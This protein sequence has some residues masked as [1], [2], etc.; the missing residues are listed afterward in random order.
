MS[1]VE[2]S[3]MKD[4]ARTE[5]IRSEGGS[6]HK[7][8]PMSDSDSSDSSQSS[9]S[10]SQ[11]GSE[12]ESNSSS[13]SEQENE[14]E[15]NIGSDKE[16]VMSE[17]YSMDSRLDIHSESS[18][19]LTTPTKLEDMDSNSQNPD[20]SRGNRQSRLKDLKVMWEENPD[21]YGVRRSGRSRKEPERYNIGEDSEEND[22]KGHQKPSRRQRDSGEWQASDSSD[23]DESEQ[24]CAKSRQKPSA[25]VST[26]GRSNR[27]SGRSQKKRPAPSRRQRKH[28]S[29]SE[30]EDEYDTDEDKTRSTRRSIKKVRYAS[31]IKF[32]IE[33]RSNFTATGADTTVYA[34]E[35]KGDPND[36]DAP[37]KEMQFLIKWK[38]WSHLHNTWESDASLRAQ[39][40]KGMKKVENY[41]KREEEIRLWKDA[42]TREDIEYYDCQ[43]EMTTELQ[44]RQ[45]LVERIIAENK[46]EHGREPDYLIKWE[47]LPYSEAT[48]EDG[49]L[50]TRK[51]KKFIDD[52]C[53]RQK[54][55]KIPTK[56]CKVLKVRPKFVP[57]KTQP[58][59][60][61]GRDGLE[62]RDYQLEGV[63]WLAHSW[64]RENGVILA[65]EMGLGKTIQT[66]GFLSYLMN[67]HSLYGPFL[68]VVPLSTMNSWQREFSLWAPE[69]NVVVYIGDISSRNSIRQYEWCHPG[70][71]RL[72]FNVLLTTYEILLK[73]KSFLGGVSWAVL[74]VDEA[75]RLK[76]D[77]SLLYKSLF[78]FDTNHRVL[79][80]GTPLQNSLK[81]LWALLHFIM[82]EKF[83]SWEDFEQEHKDSADKGYS[84][85]HKQLEPFILRRVKKDVEKSLPAKVEQ[86]LRVEMSSIQKQYYRWILTKNYR[87]LSKGLKGSVAG[88][89]NI[90]MELKKCCNH[91][92]LIRPP[93]NMGNADIL[94]TIVRGSG[95]L[96]LL[97]K[98]L[99]RLKETGHRVLI[100]S[101]MVQMLDIISD[102]LQLK[103]FTFQRLDGSIRGEQRRQALDHFNAEDSQDF[104][105]ILS[106]RAGGLGINL[107]TADTVII[108]D[109]DWNPQNDLQAQARAHRIG[110]KKQV[111]IYRLVTKGSVEED[112]IERAK[113]KMVLDH[114]VIQRM[115]TTGRTVL[116]RSAKP[117]NNTTPFNKEELSAILKFGAEDLFK[118][119]EEGSEE[120]QVDI[121]EILKRAETRE[122]QSASA[123]DE[124]L[125]AFK[126]ASFNFTEVEE[127]MPVDEPA[128]EERTVGINWEEIIPE[129]ERKKVED[130]E[131]KKEEMELLLPPRSRKPVRQPGHSDSDEDAKKKGNRDAGDESGS[132]KEQSD[133]DRP[134]KRGRPRTVNRDAI[135]GFND[136]EIR[137]FV[138]SFKKFASPMNRLESIAMDA[139]LTEK[140][141]GDLKRLADLLYNGCQTAMTDHAL[142]QD[143]QNEDSNLS[144]GTATGKRRDR[145]PSIKLSGVT[146]NAKTVFNAMK[147]LEPLETCLPTD[148]KQRLRWEMSTVCKD[149]HWDVPWCKEDDSRLL[150][151]IYEYGMGNWESIKMDPNLELGEK[152]LPDGDQ[153]PQAKQLQTRAD[154]LLKVLHRTLERQKAGKEKSKKIKGPR[155]SRLDKTAISK[156]FVEIEDSSDSDLSMK[157]HEERLKSS[158]HKIAE[159][160]DKLK[161][162]NSVKEK[163]S[164]KKNK[165]NNH[166]RR[167]RIYWRARHVMMRGSESRK[168]AVALMSLDSPRGLVPSACDITDMVSKQKKSEPPVMHYTATA[169]PQVIDSSGDLE[170]SIFKECKEKMRPVKKALKQIDNPDQNLEKE[171]QLR[172]TRQCLLKIGDRIKE[173]LAE[174]NDAEKIKEW[175]NYLWTFVSKFTEFNAKKLYKLYRQIVKR[176]VEDKSHSL[177][178]KEGHRQRTEEAK[179]K[180][181]LLVDKPKS[182][183]ESSQH[184]QHSAK[185]DRS[186]SSLK[187][188]FEGEMYTSERLSSAK[189]LYDGRDRYLERKSDR[190]E[191]QNPSYQRDKMSSYSV[192]KGNSYQ[193][194]GQTNSYSGP[195][196]RKHWD[197]HERWPHNNPSSSWDRHPSE[198]RRD[199]Q[200]G[201]FREEGPSGSYKR[202][203]EAVPYPDRTHAEMRDPRF[204]HHMGSYGV[205][206]PQYPGQA[207]YGFVPHQPPPPGVEDR[208]PYQGEGWR[209]KWESGHYLAKH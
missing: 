123:G 94:Q 75:H 187:R 22:S 17:S 205:Y 32:Q 128:E 65:D 2:D 21:M 62:L 12:S 134:R 6:E 119:N 84:K 56:V 30:D 117:T 201:Y 184:S 36:A 47:G 141:M 172:H 125:S 10:S 70:N 179:S 74:G 152:I 24:E 98:L 92:S 52:F 160:A 130:E 188:Q 157:K 199:T 16:D 68:L 206:Q 54:N 85:L 198:F 147:D 51:F 156:Q 190:R 202:E 174:L 43:Q 55:Q 83:R 133:D 132:E 59:Y 46:N 151:G 80:T 53:A 108:F 207:N 136:A 177:K 39:G 14:P 106:T 93:D 23:K 29:S 154:Y 110:Q 122:D 145:G 105:F 171:E 19:G 150:I 170:P 118:E 197:S 124:L 69:V 64:C 169:E 111:N 107:A 41:V 28:S 176:S 182:H 73:D 38:G 89:V 144:V 140:A 1:E 195:P 71:K 42:A 87:A 163:S 120:P 13:D 91:A 9:G 33:I 81:E 66:I 27:T 8:D 109:S 116:S 26:F 181:R 4:V 161:D 76:N 20:S 126:V 138:R 31:I 196:P 183:D 40:A 155:K 37:E 158:D 45:M 57:F 121:D 90:I 115:D 149:T 186:G 162:G 77:D 209:G 143:N 113:R 67:Q 34:I 100:F 49:A 164:S 3:V 129:E 204:H 11:S 131:R 99:C 194:K 35:E 159:G 78:E 193:R 178:D 25:G 191:G 50:V 82:R 63:N 165:R 208:S 137:R 200:R 18:M 60:I 7:S 167:K 189:R 101:Q 146:V 96:I 180:H 142:K 97:D 127:E 61:G 135:K 104:C 139:D 185:S 102:Y 168:E 48:W 203:R 112:I 15:K 114:L 95:K 5:E 153:K 173:C 86:I 88:F 103:H 72:K 192:M 148:P 79:I 58:E 44:E 175:R 166:L